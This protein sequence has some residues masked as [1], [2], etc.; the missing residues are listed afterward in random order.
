MRYEALFTLITVAPLD[1]I[2]RNS[3]LAQSAII[4]FNS[5]YLLKRHSFSI[6]YSS[7]LNKDL[8]YLVD[9]DDKVLNNYNIVC[10]T[11]GSKISEKIG[12]Y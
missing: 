1:I 8:H 10:V 11:D 9:F 4:Q 2:N 3:K 12:L 7:F 6:F 5:H